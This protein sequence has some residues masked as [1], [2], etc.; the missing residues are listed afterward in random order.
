MRPVRIIA[1]A[2]LVGVLAMNILAFI[3]WAKDPSVTG[4][5][6]P[7]ILLME[8]FS[9]IWPVEVFCDFMASP[10]ASRKLFDVAIVIGIF[11][12]GFGVEKLVTNRLSKK[13]ADR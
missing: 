6:L 5:D 2:Y 11:A 3:V 7:T 1:A 4:M 12:I 13:I 9:L 8:V 10:T